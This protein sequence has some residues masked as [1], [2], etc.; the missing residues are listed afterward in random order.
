MTKSLTKKITIGAQTLVPTGKI[1]KSLAL[2]LYRQMLLTYEFED[3]LIKLYKQGEIFGGLF[4]GCGNEAV[5]VGAASVLEDGDVMAPSHRDIGAHFVR[6]ETFEGMMLQIMARASGQTK[7]RDNS[8]HQG[9]MERGIISLIS[10][11]ATSPML[12]AGCALAHKMKGND[13]V[14]LATIGEGSTSLGDF[15]EVMN[16]ASVLNLPFILII[17]NNQFAYSTPTYNQYKCEL[18]SDRAISYGIPGITIDGTDV[19]L[20]YQTVNAAVKRARA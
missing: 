11:L 4:T 1:S 15:H 8:A 9:S 10:H 20:V 19:E 7:G 6:G 16:F 2:D 14:A 17:E 5:S 3:R 12:A 18:L 13:R